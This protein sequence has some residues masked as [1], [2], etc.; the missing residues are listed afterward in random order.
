MAEK[1]EIPRSSRCYIKS[2][3]LLVMMMLLDDD[4]AAYRF[5][6][7][8]IR[9]FLGDLETEIMEAVWQSSEGTVTVKDIFETLKKDREIAYTTVMTT[10]NRLVDKGVLE[11]VDKVGLANCYVPTHSRDGF[12]GS[13]VEKLLGGLLQDF[14]EH[15]MS[16]L[17]NLSKSDASRK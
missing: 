14:P 17:S 11:I 15:S 4:N 16:F 13:F 9:K 6:Q 5:N 10:M 3:L 2:H 7:Y 1:R 8:G 12:I